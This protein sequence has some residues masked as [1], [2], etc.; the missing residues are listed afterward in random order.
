MMRI[1]Q[2]KIT[3]TL[4]QAFVLLSCIYMVATPTAY[5]QTADEAGKVLMAIG[6]VK[7]VRK[8]QSI[9]LTR[10]ASIQ[11]GDSLITG[12]ASNAQ[13]RMS[14]GAIIA[15]R[16]QTEFKID[17]Y[18][19]NGK[20]DGSEKASLS[21]VKGGVRAV[22]GAIGQQN[23]D[24]LQVN[25]VVATVGIRGT[26]FNINY[27]EANCFNQ[28]K[29][30]AK[31]G[32][33]AGVFEGQITVK[34]EAKT[35]TL[36]VNQFLYVA[37][38]N[39]APVRLST[40]P[41][42]LPDPLSGQKAAK[43][44]KSNAAEIPSLNAAVAPPRQPADSQVAPPFSPLLNVGGITINQA[45]AITVTGSFDPPTTW[46][47]KPNLGNGYTLQSF[48]QDNPAK[49]NYLY[50]LQLA[51][52]W[53]AG[54]PGMDGLPPHNIGTYN[55]DRDLNESPN[56]KANY[57]EQTYAG[58]GT[59][60]QPTNGFQVVN[61]G[62]GQT[63]YPNQITLASGYSAKDHPGVRVNFAI[64]D[65][66]Q[67][68]GGNYGVEITPGV[69]QGIV[70]W[71]RW[72][73]GNV[74]QISAYGTPPGDLV[75]IPAGSGFH[76]VV[77]ELFNITLA[78]V[79]PTY[80]FTLMGATTP[81]AVSNPQG[82]WLVTGGNLTANLATTASP[83]ISGNLSL[84]TSQ[85]AGYGN[86]NMAFA[87]SGPISTISPGSNVALA[88]TQVSTAVTKQ[89]G[90]LA[91]CAGGCAGSGN[92]SFYGSSTAAATGPQAA[93]LSYNFNTGSNVVQGVAVFKR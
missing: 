55:A 15:L 69:Y 29:T 1:L 52:T 40:P 10:G 46:Y 68:E 8:G 3:R 42:F 22:T 87:S 31:D 21:L 61:F 62:T 4:M 2:Q 5:A 66:Q 65:A 39:T 41:N 77:G 79:A 57:G 75:Y 34:N 59:T 14:D 54:T 23:K 93:G 82:T 60:G 71:G 30:P 45:P 28:N 36:G 44:D 27:C 9:P 35:D 25:A 43:K 72:A 89:N 91:T 86:Y 56:V 70:S 19:Y 51:E 24:N 63:A 90:T 13:V 58:P 73:N 6:E 17:E 18:K 11:A 33:Y 53:P 81:T 80:N 88:Q 83:G 20:Q 84:Y 37:D 76:Y 49:P 67:K 12:I 16:A 26:G 78:P 64:G 92:V 50:Y 85:T 38:K 7:A 47:N 32:L 74:Q 48:Y